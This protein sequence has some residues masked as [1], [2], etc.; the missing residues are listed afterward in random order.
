MNDNLKETKYTRASTINNIQNQYS[1]FINSF[2]NKEYSQLT[3]PS[4]DWNSKNLLSSYV[5][6]N[7]KFVK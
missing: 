3:S 7:L 1:N 6:Q 4:K 5:Q 2:E